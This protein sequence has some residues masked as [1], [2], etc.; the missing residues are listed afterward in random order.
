MKGINIFGASDRKGR[1]PKGTIVSSYPGWYNKAKLDM[2]RD[3]INQEARRIDSGMIPYAE[4]A[5]AKADLRKR[6]ENYEAVMRGLP[7]L[8]SKQKDEVSRFVGS[9]GE[10]I[11]ESYFTRTSMMKG[12]ADAH[13]EASRMTTPCIPLDGDVAN[14]CGVKHQGGKV[15]RNGASK[16]W[17]I[18]RRMLGE[19]VNPE[20]LR[21]D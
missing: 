12:V 1:S 16:I 13:E 3:D 11:A 9:L 4:V 19:S 18:G 21:K 5:Q 8:S 2:E 17:Q 14:A 7:K 10:K 20:I 15:S 6:K